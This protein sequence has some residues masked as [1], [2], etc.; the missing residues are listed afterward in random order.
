M[1]SNEN[2]N[3]AQK[4]KLIDNFNMQEIF[5]N[6]YNDTIDEYAFWGE[7]ITQTKKK[8]RV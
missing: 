6:L 3:M 4:I 8:W 5:D 2:L 1:K 7:G